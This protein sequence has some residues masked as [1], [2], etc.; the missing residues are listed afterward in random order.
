MS[1]SKIMLPQEI[2]VRYL[3]IINGI[4]FT[5]K[6]VE[7]ISCIFNTRG[8]SKIASLLAISSKTVGAHIAN[9]KNKI[10]CNT[11]EDIIDF[12]EKSEDHSLINHHYQNIKIRHCFEQHLKKI[13]IPVSTSRLTCE[14]TSWLDE[15]NQ[16]TF[17]I[18]LTKLLREQ[19]EKHLESIKVKTTLINKKVNQFIFADKDSNND[20][21]RIH[22]LPE[23]WREQFKDQ[24]KLLIYRLTHADDPDNH[25]LLLL[26]ERN[27]SAELFSE[28]FSKQN[29]YFAAFKLLKILFPDVELDKIIS[30]F[31][32]QCKLIN[33]SV[34]STTLP[35][36][37]KM[38][39]ET[40]SKIN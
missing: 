2:Y 13:R 8:A 31:E 6:E 17:P 37:S 4:K 29:Y 39:G 20:I 19:L 14:I 16:S 22:I 21:Y 24:E 30:E 36:W 12:V 5:S 40:L 27:P 26:L 35:P 7:V 23:T 32:K 28:D 25:I 18:T 10:G 38:Y 1:D 33:N 3:E 9:I 34:D 15:G 11:Q